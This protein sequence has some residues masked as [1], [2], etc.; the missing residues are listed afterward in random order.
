MGIFNL[1][2]KGSE[3]GTGGKRRGFNTLTVSSIE[4]LTDST[5]KISFEIPEAL[6]KDYQFKAGQYLD[7]IISIDDKEEHR[8]YSICSGENEDL[9]VAVKKVEHGK[10]SHW[11]NNQLKAGDQLLVSK[12]QGN[13]ILND[14]QKLNVAIVAGSGITPIMAMAKKI[15][16]IG[17]NLTLFYGNRTQQEIIFHNELK[18][19]KHT[20]TTY[21]LSSEEAIGFEKGRLNKE[22]FV[23][24]IKANLDLLQAD[25][26]Y[27][28]GPEQLIVDI[29]STLEFF[30]VPK[31]K[32]HF[33]LF[34]TP[35]LLKQEETLVAG[36]F[37]GVSK[38]KAILDSEVVSFDLASKGKTVL[39][40]VESAGLDAPYSCKGGVCCSCKAKVI[41]GN[42][43]MTMNYS[44]TDEEVREGYIL[45]CQAHP[46]S[47]EL[48]ISFD[49]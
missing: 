15:E 5:K 37:E 9:S 48:V 10:I 40:A 39:E 34:T 47:E 3:Q 46:A 7:F 30:G 42:A 43:T 12:P 41:K 20:N 33:E 1:F 6:K 4:Q 27:L 8:A 14:P 18:A 49:E 16:S 2:K 36:S 45:T 44:L 31:H 32:I 28:C 23:E 26:F 22:N 25:G 38:V 24:K 11:L 13:F 29:S 19:L 35:V 17:G 21:Y